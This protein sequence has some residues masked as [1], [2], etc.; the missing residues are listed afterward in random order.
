VGDFAAD[1]EVVGSEGRYRA[2]LSSDWE[3]WGPNGGYVASIALRAAGAE[4]RFARPVSFSGQFLSVAKFEDVDIDV[5]VLRATRVADALL[6]RMAQGDRLVHV[7]LVWTVDEVDGLEHDAAPMPE[8]PR[9]DEL[10]TFEELADGERP[11]FV[12]WDNL[13]QRPVDW[14]ENWDEREPGAPTHR[15][16][17]KFRPRALFDDPYVD[18]ARSLLLLDTL[19]W[20]AAVRAHSRPI[21]FL[22]PSLDISAQFHRLAPHQEWLYLE[23]SAQVA[24]D[25]LIGCSGRSWS[26]DGA[27]LA[28]AGSQLVCRPGDPQAQVPKR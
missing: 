28:S 12:F 5:E 2:T 11:L 24:A 6:V 21:E 17:F 10:K 15:G 20:P 23:V 1:T 18:A 9:P 25:G 7:A 8:V 27:L 22:A 14:I 16:W 19:G 3:I 4:S 26:A 13:E